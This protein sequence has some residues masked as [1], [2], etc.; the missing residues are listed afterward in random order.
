[1]GFEDIQALH[2]DCILIA[3]EEIARIPVLGDQAQGLLRTHPADQDGR[4]RPGERLRVVDR[5]GQLEVFALVSGRVSRP[6]LRGN[7]EG[8]L[9]H[10]EAFFDRWEIQAQAFGLVLVPGRADPEI[11]SPTGKHVQGGDGF[12]HHGGVAIDHASN[13]QA[14]LDLLGDSGEEAQGSVAFDHPV[15]RLTEPGAKL[16]EVIH[17]PD[18]IETALVDRL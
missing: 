14:D 7:L 8:L 1:M 18:A 6:H 13:Q 15:L 5:V 3:T 17:D 9:Q 2:E 11:G 4:V 10:F 12:D 16:E